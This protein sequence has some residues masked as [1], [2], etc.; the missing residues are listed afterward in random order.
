MNDKTNRIHQTFIRMR[1]FG[2]DHASEFAADGLGKKAFT[3]LDGIIAELEKYTAAQASGFGRKRHGTI[4][5]AESRE[6]LRD[7]VS[8]VS[9]TAEVL[10][11]VPGV[12]GNFELPAA[13]SDRALLTCARAFAADLAPFATQFEAQELPGLRGYDAMR[14]LFFEE[15]MVIRIS[16]DTIALAPALIATESDITRMVDGVRSVLSR[17]S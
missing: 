5:R 10:A 13:N 11:E 1:D 9:R 15:N 17:L 4:T 6:E 16:G 2:R 7:L 3:E 12:E 8:A 14:R